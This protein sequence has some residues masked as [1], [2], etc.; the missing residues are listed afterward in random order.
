MATTMVYTYH[1]DLK[2]S[3][4][5]VGGSNKV[6]GENFLPFKRYLSKTTKEALLS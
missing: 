3:S 5:H 6:S 2:I 1:F 4:I